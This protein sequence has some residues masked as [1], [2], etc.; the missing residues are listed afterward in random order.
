MTDQDKIREA[1]KFYEEELKGHC[2]HDEVAP[3]KIALAALKTMEWMDKLDTNCY[4]DM[5]CSCGASCR[6]EMKEELRGKFQSNLNK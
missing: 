6:R 1:I 2:Y 5:G 3:F 4:C